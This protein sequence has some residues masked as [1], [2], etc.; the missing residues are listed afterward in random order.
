L[1]LNISTICVYLSW[2]RSTSR[3]FVE[4]FA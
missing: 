4:V 2:K 1:R 3:E